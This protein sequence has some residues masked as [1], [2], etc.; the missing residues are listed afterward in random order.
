ME[1]ILQTKIFRRGYLGI[2]ITVFLTNIYLVIRY[3]AL[4]TAESAHTFIGA[5]VILVL[6][7]VGAVHIYRNDL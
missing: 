6:L 5:M 3:Q 1:G 4:R 7:A 2:A